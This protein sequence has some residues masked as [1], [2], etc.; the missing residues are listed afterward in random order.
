MST[1][2]I[3]ALIASQPISDKQKALSSAQPVLN[4]DH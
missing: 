1:I 3:K 2:S 4:L